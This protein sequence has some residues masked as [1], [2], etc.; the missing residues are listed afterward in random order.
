MANVGRLEEVGV[1]DNVGSEHHVGSEAVVELL[2]DL[3]IVAHHTDGLDWYTRA[4]IERSNRLKERCHA[5][6]S[7][8]ACC[9]RA[10]SWKGYTLMSMP[11]SLQGAERE[12][13]RERI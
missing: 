12:R 7:L 9:A 1:G 11:C 4:R 2:V 5:I 13:E 8:N 3:R 6:N 10:D